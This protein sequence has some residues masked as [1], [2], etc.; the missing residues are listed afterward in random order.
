MKEVADYDAL[1][2]HHPEIG[3]VGES[4]KEMGLMLCKKPTVKSCQDGSY[5]IRLVWRKRKN[6]LSTIVH[7]LKGIRLKGFKNG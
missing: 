1:I 4:A 3:E 5:T 6:P 7:V 2:K